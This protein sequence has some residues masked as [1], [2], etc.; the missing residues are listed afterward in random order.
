[1][2]RVHVVVHGMVQGVGFRFSARVEAQ[3]HG[4]TGWVRNR[5][6]GAVEAE[7]EG[8]PAAIDR[9]LAW[10]DEG[11]PGASVSSMTSSDLEPTG[12]PGFRVLS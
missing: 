8:E 2:V 12:E 11:P 6:D 5:S 9:M 1:M 4:V 10:F 3:R 7:L